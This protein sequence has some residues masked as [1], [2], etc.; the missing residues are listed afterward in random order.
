MRDECVEKT[1][2]KQTRKRSTEKCELKMLEEVAEIKPS[3][4]EINHFP[5]ETEVS[6]VPMADI[7]CHEINFEAKQVK[8]VEEVLSGFTYFRDNDVLMAKITPCFENGKADVAKKLKNGIG[9]GST[10]YIVIR[11]NP[12]IVYPEWIY[13]HINSADFMNGGKHFMT[14]TAGQQRI[15]LNYV[16]K[17]FI[18]VPSL[19]V[20]KNI[21]DKI[22]EEKRMIEPSKKLIEVFTNKIAERIKAILGN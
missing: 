7:N 22:E 16:K 13:Y 18:P 1:T 10:K 17:Y 5:Q 2:K 15:D 21:L 4:D 8:K 14:G 19:E 9:F 3:K 6:F 12:E 11:A 20:Q